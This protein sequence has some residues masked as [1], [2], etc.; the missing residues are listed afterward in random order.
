MFTVPE[1]ALLE[2]VPMDVGEANEPEASL[3]WAVYVFDVNVPL[4]VKATVPL[5][6]ELAVTQN[7]EVDTAPVVTEPPAVAVEVTPMS[8]TANT[9]RVPALPLA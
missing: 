5:A 4:E 7:G 9:G 2:R 8:S 1:L 6:V 3:N